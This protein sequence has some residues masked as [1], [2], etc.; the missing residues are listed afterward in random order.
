MKIVQE[1]ENALKEM[2]SHGVTRAT[3]RNKYHMTEYG[4]KKFTD[5][6]TTREEE[7]DDRGKKK[8]HTDKDVFDY[9]QETL[10]ETIPVELNHSEELRKTQGEKQSLTNTAQNYL[11]QLETEVKEAETP[12]IEWSEEAENN[13]NGVDI[14]WHE[15]DAHFGAVVEN[16]HGETIYDSSI[17]KDR[18]L[19]RYESFN[20]LLESYAGKVDTIH[21]LLGGDLVEG[22]GIFHGQGH[23]VDGYINN[24][25]D[26]AREEYFKQIKALIS[27]AQARNAK[28]QIITVPGNHG[29]VRVSSSSN[30]ANFDDLLY[31]SLRHMTAI[32]LEDHK[33]RESVRFKHSD[34]T[35]GVTFPLRNHTGYLTHGQNM[36]EHVGTA[37]GK[38]DALAKKDRFG[39]DILFRGHYHMN[40]IEPVNGAPIVMTNSPKPGGSYE[41]SISAYGS[42]GS[43]FYVVS[44]K[45]V[46]E[47][48]KYIKY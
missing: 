43:A 4:A 33:M 35:T 38:R 15:T 45:N 1:F 25:F 8:F 39:F 14:V 32:Y 5:L 28:L 36:K 24:Q 46:L 23:E 21:F 18:F 29:D 48:V 30:K 37:S 42:P 41:D 12:S 47:D 20:N 9:S 34:R 13:S 17:A 27:E 40:K 6:T 44:D 7:I 16:E 10:N 26:T 3:L 22:T 19:K 11:E 31:N 2:Q